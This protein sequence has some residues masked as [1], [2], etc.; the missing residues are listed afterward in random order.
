MCHLISWVKSEDGGGGGEGKA[1]YIG[2][3]MVDKWRPASQTGPG[4]LPYMNQLDSTALN[5]LKMYNFHILHSVYSSMFA[6][7]NAL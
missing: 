5:P 1:K 6:M 3:D 2:P 7:Y 4:I